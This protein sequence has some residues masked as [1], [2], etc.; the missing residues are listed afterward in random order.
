MIYY[1]YIDIS[2]CLLHKFSN[3]TPTRPRAGRAESDLVHCRL[4]QLAQHSSRYRGVYSLLQYFWALSM[5]RKF[6][7]FTLPEWI[8]TFRLPKRNYLP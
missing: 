5:F 4:S 7:D 6:S 3:F 2:F 8:V 1:M